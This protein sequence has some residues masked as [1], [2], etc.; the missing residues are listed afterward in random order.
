MVAASVVPPAG[1]VKIPSVSA[2]SWMAPMI[3][4]SLTAAP[5]PPVAFTH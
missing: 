5:A 2:S 4:S 3:A 1:S